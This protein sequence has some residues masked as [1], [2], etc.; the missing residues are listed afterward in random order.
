MVRNDNFF[1]GHGWMINELGLKGNE[2]I[3]YAII[4]GFSQT[5]KQNFTGSAQYLAD[6]T[7]STVRGVQKNIKALQ[8]KG[9]LLVIKK[10]PTHSEYHAIVPDFERSKDEN[11]YEQSSQLITNKVRNTYEQS[12]QDL[13][14]KVRNTYEQSSYNNINNKNKRI[15][16][17]DRLLIKTGLAGSKNNIPTLEEVKQYAADNHMQLD[18]VKFFMK[19]DARGWITKKGE[20]V[21]NWKLLMWSWNDKEDLKN[22]VKQ[23]DKNSFM[24]NTYD[25]DQ[26]EKDFMRN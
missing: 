1:V 13:T 14:N 25:F 10:D 9:L 12:S 24:Q 4:Y 26:L 2:L 18:P 15:Y 8:E 6:W 11:T 19:N 22:T 5:K 7:N 16:K 23:P 3:I 17:T 20:P 21:K